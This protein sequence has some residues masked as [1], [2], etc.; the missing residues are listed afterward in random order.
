MRTLKCEVSSVVLQDRH[1]QRSAQIYIELSI[2]K[3]H[4]LVG[5]CH[6]PL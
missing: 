6:F 4:S 5:A 3:K 1:W 2:R